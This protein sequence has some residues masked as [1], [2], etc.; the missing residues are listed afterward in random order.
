M[1]KTQLILSIFNIFHLFLILY[2]NLLYSFYLKKNNISFDNSEI[3]Y[4]KAI[5]NFFNLIKY[6]IIIYNNRIS[7]KEI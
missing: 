6:L 3:Y 5:L 4:I 1:E 7:K 2:F